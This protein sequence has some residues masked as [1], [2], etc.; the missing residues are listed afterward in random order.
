MRVSLVLTVDTD[1]ST[2]GYSV[3]GTHLSQTVRSLL[4]EFL[5][6]FVSF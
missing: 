4:G 6:S 2:N 5:F 1:G 3:R